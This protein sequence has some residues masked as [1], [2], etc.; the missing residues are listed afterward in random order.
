MSRTN[1]RNA[2]GA[3]LKN[4]AAAQTGAV[5]FLSN[6]YSHPPKLTNQ[7]DF[8]RDEDPGLGTGAAVYLH[9]K[10]S[11]QR[12]VTGGPAATPTMPNTPA[13]KVKYYTL[14]L[15]CILRSQKTR[16]QDTGA[17]NDL[18]LDSLESYIL[19][20][21]NAGTQNPGQGGFGPYAGTGYIF[22]WG[23]GDEFGASDIHVVAGMPKTLKSGS[24]QVY[25]TM[26]ILVLEV[27]N[28]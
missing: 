22:Q 28:T 18:F 13:R 12:R 14:R 21:R 11:S 15:I 6:V 8:T 2:I 3:Y 10:E 23:E 5:Q 7:G 16:S 24:M 25:S 27:L 19:Q 1:V 20:N 9:L 17:D 26:D 4:G